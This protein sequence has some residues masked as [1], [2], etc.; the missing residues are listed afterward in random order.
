MP[1]AIP[2]PNALEVTAGELSSKIKSKIYLVNESYGLLA[3]F[4]A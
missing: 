2:R 1:K 4:Y 3:C